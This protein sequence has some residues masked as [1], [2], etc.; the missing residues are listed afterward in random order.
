MMFDRTQ[1]MFYLKFVSKQP[2]TADS[3]ILA[4]K[5]PEIVARMTERQKN[6]PH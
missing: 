5:A 3:A 2:N 4:V 6:V 1:Q